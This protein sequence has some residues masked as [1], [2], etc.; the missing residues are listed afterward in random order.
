MP[1]KKN[2]HTVKAGVF[3]VYNF[4]WLEVVVETM[5]RAVVMFVVHSLSDQF[6]F[7]Q[8]SSVQSEHGI[9]VSNICKSA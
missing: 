5:F 9:Y 4:V 7:Q 2:A 8:Y 3:C 6:F 1:L